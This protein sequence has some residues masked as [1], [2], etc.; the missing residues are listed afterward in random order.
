MAKNEASKKEKKFEC[1]LCKKSKGASSMVHIDLVRPSLISAIQFS[2]PK[3]KPSGY[4]CKL[5]LNKVKND[6][7]QGVLEDEKGRL[8]DIEKEVLDSMKEHEI[9]SENIN[10][11][12]DRE[13]TFGERMSDKVAEFGGSWFFIISFGFVMFLWVLMNVYFLRAKPFD[14]YPFILLNL[15]LSTLAALQ[16]PIIMMSQNRQEDKDRLRSEYDYKINLKAELEIRHLNEKI[17]HLL[18]HQWQR[19]LEIQELQLDLMNEMSVGKR[20]VKR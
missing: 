2:H 5:D 13:L 9:L 19:L 12:F 8:S 16:A 7:V 15:V 3:W 11:D 20:S 6:Y 4:I 18:Q 14:P 17:D 1:S 10:S